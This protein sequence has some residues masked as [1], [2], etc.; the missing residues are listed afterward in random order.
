MNEDFNWYVDELTKR[1]NEKRKK[2]E[3]EKVVNRGLEIFEN[4]T[5]IGPYTRK[6][7]NMFYKRKNNES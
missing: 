6:L 4:P 1:I 3:I 7:L 5:P 2:E